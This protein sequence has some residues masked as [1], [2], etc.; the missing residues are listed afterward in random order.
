MILVT[1]VSWEGRHVRERVADV[2]AREREKE[3]EKGRE[4]ETESVQVKSIPIRGRQGFL[5]SDD[6]TRVWSSG[7]ISRSWIY[8][9]M[10]GWMYEESQHWSWSNSSAASGV[11]VEGCR[12]VGFV[13]LCSTTSGCW[14]PPVGRGT[15]YWTYLPT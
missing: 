7:G 9:H 12:G 4:R 1:A 13:S 11:R 15:S 2:S 10:Y 14:A 3:G 5:S 6:N 8:I